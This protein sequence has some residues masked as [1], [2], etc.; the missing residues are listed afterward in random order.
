MTKTKSFSN[1]RE[2]CHVNHTGIFLEKVWSEWTVKET[3]EVSLVRRSKDYVPGKGEVCPKV[4]QNSF[5]QHILTANLLCARHHSRE[6]VI[7]IYGSRTFQAE[8]RA[9]LWGRSLLDLIEEHPGSRWAKEEW[10]VV[11]SEG[12]D[13]VTSHSHYKHLGIYKDGQPVEAPT[14]ECHD[15]T[16][17]KQHHCWLAKAERG[18]AVRRLL[19][20]TGERMTTDGGSD[21]VGG[22]EGWVFRYILKVQLA[23]FA[24]V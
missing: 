4:Y 16:C 13:H 5:I 7:Q 12:K 22:I 19:P 23:S 11:K 20:H 21:Q 2:R 3:K 24:N 6:Q 8:G 9:R 17:H 10:R 1:S 14:W 15:V 18:R